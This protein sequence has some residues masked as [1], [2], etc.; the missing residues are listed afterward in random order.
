MEVIE[1]I[2]QLLG[3]DGKKMADGLCFKKLTIRGETTM[4]PL[5]K[6][7]AKENRNSMAKA[8]YDNQFQR[9]VD[10]INKS[11][12]QKEKVTNFIGG[13]VFF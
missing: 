5:N 4:T 13:F 12:V 3:I 11:L 8:I 6:H 9:I 7:Q 2:S 1:K 10:F